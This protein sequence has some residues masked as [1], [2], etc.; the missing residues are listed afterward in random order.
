MARVTIFT[1]AVL[2]LLC[3]IE[4]LCTTARGAIGRETQTLEGT[5]EIIFDPKNEGRDAKWHL[6]EVF[7]SHPAVRRI[8]VPSCWELTEKDYEG[9]AYYRRGFQVPV[10]WKGKVVRLHFD[11]V[12][13]LCEVWLNGTAVGFHEGGFT[14][15]EFR[16]D[17]LLKFDAENTLILRVAGPIL[18]QDKQVDGVGPMETP[19]WRGAIT[20]GIWQPVRLVATSEIY[21]DDVFIE[22]NITDRSAT[23]HVKLNHQAEG[24]VSAR[25]ELA[26]SPAHRPDQTVANIYPDLQQFCLDQQRI[27][28]TANQ[29]MIEAVRCN[30]QVV[31]YC[32]H[33]LTAG[34]WILG[35]GLL[36]LFRNP[37]THA[38]EGTRAANQPRIM[39]IRVRPRN[40]YAPRDTQIQIS[41]VNELGPI[42]GKLK[43]QVLGDDGTTVFARTLPTGL[44]AGISPLFTERLDTELLSGTYTVKAELTTVEGA[45]ITENEYRFDVFTADQLA[46]PEQ[47]VAV[48]DASNSLKPFLKI[49]GI[50]FEDFDAETDPA[51]P[52]LVSRTV[53]GTPAQRTRFRELEEFIKGGGTGVYL[54]GGGPHVP[55]GKAG[56]ASPL[57]PIKARLK[58]ALG[59][60]ICVPHLVH[61][62]PIFDGLPT[63]GM[64][65]SLYENVWA[66]STLLDVNGELVV[67]SIGYDWFPDY[68]RS[69]RHYYGPGDVWWGAD[70]AIVPLGK[71][72]CIASQL[73][74][75]EN[76]GKDPVADKILFNLIKFAARQ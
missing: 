2:L 60:W 5:W 27:H 64:M 1:L 22:P 15:F 40:V 36:D 14:P 47:P 32:I 9:V 46:F 61:D 54:Q 24:T 33:A 48:L 4:A 34:D 26:V 53:A 59:N 50:E 19:Q 66:Q 44:A 45:L 70:L 30:P 20:G 42:K 23:F 71:G 11:A 67:G 10:D 17:D 16:V 39:S 12:N 75:C 25:I 51:L 29:R 69:Q 18:L 49:S 6:D 8:P 35:A 65:G 31:G 13:F 43:V 56:A 28:G 57:L 21:V 73:R 55:W 63:R 7:S 74:L 41:G 62:H 76:L 72:R 58:R 38:Y 52:V 3:A 68:D 37:K